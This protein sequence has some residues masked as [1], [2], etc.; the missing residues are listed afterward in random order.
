MVKMRNAYKHLA[1]K[2]E[3]KKP[4]TRPSCR[5]EDDIRM[6]LRKV[7]WESV[8]RMYL[9][10]GTA[11]WLHRVNTVMNLRVPYETGNFLTS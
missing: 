1:G 3:G 11:Q 6:D 2:P 7:V 10:Q 9:A 8:E 4:L 5:W